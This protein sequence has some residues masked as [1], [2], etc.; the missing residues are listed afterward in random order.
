M[1]KNQMHSSVWI[2]L[3]LLDWNTNEH[4]FYLGGHFKV[5]PSLPT[6]FKKSCYHMQKYR[7]PR[8]HHYQSPSLSC[9][10]MNPLFSGRPNSWADWNLPIDPASRFPQKPMNNFRW[11]LQFSISTSILPKFPPRLHI[12]SIWDN[13]QKG[14]DHKALAQAYMKQH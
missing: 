8:H 2:S 9:R 11:A 7:F 4:R 14:R 1:L 13:N 5:N 6:G 10:N 3:A 12:H